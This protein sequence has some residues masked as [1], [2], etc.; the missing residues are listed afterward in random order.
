MQ[1]WLRT[2]HQVFSSSCVCTS[3]LT[4]ALQDLM[5]CLDDETD[6]PRSHLQ[7]YVEAT[8]IGVVRRGRRR[9]PQF[10][11]SLRN[12]NTRVGKDPRRNNS[13]KDGIIL[14]ISV[15]QSPTRRSVD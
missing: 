5:A 6:E 15:L 14:S 8:W 12:V 1:G 9:R 2:M 3:V 4:E 7:S 13:I 10:A 11:I